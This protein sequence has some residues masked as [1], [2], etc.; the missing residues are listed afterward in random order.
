MRTMPLRSARRAVFLTL[1]AAMVL[2]LSLNGVGATQ[3]P[4]VAVAS[5]PAAPD[6]MKQTRAEMEAKS[7]GCVT[8]H[9][10]TEPMHEAKTVKLVFTDCHGGDAAATVKELAHVKPRHPELWKTAANPKGSFSALNRE[11]PEFVKFVNPSDLR[12][13]P[14]TC[15]TATCHAKEVANVS[16]SMMTHGAMLW[17]AALYNNGSYPSKTYRFGESYDRDGNPRRLVTNPPPTAAE[18]AKGVLPFLDPL[19]RW[20]VTQPGNVLRVFERGGRPASQTGLP[21]KEEAPGRPEVKL[22]VRGVG[23]NLRTDPVFLNLQKTRVLD[24]SLSF[25]GT[26]D[27]AGDYRSSGCAACHVPYANDRDPEH[28]GPWAVH[29][30]QGQSAQADPT[31]PKYEPGHPIK[32]QFTRAIPSSQCMVCHMHQGNA[33]VNSYYGAIW[34]DQETDGALMYPK[35][36]LDP[37]SKRVAEVHRHNP[38]GAAERG[39]WGDEKFLSKVS[40][41]NPKMRHTQFADYHGHGW[42]F[43]YVYKQ[44]RKGNLLDAKGQQVSHADPE[45]FK[46]AVHLKDIH[47][48]K[49]MHCVDCHF[50]KDSHGNGKLYGEIGNAIEIDCIDCHGTIDR[51]ANLVTSGTMAG[52]GTSLAPLRTPFGKKRFEFRSGKLLQ[53]SMV[54]QGVEWEVVQTADTVDPT[55]PH[56]SERSRLAKTLRKDG[57]SWGDVP[58]SEAQLA[59]ANN[60]M[61]CYACHSAWITSCFGCHLPMKANVRKPM[62]HNEGDVTRNYTTY[63]PQVLRDDVYMLGV[64]GTAKGNRVA[65]VRSSSAIIV[66]STNANREALYSQQQTFSAGGYS[67]QAFNPHVPHT[68]RSTETK[69]CT[70][71][72]VSRKGDNNAWMAQLLLQGTNF[73]NFMGRYAYVAEGHEGLEAVVVTERDEPQAVIGSYLQSIAYPRNFSRFVKEGRKLD[74]AYEHDGEEIRSLQLRGEYLYTARGPGGFEIYDVANIDN[75]GFSERIISS[76]VSPLGQRTFVR[77]KYATAVALPSTL[78]VDTRR[79]DRPENQEQKAHPIYDYAFVTDRHEGLIVIDTH[80]LYDGDP[81]NNFMRRAATW[82]PDGVLDGAENIT[83][84]GNFA[85]VS[86]RKGLVIVD[87]DRPTEPKLAAVVGAPSI[88]EPRFVAVQFRYAFVCDRHGVQVLDV[89]DPRSPRAVPGA[90]IPLRDARSIYLARTYAY[91]AAGPKGLVILDVENP[92]KPFID[93]TFDDGGR[94]N[95]AHDVKVASTNASLFA[96]IADGENGLKVLQL[97]SPEETPGNYGFSPRPAPRVI[98]TYKTH[99]PALAL[100]KGLDRDRAVD[101]SYNQVAVFGRLGSRPF[102]AD[103]AR[104]LF[105]DAQGKPYSVSDEPPGPAT[106]HASEL[107]PAEP[108]AP[109]AGAAPSEPPATGRRLR[110]R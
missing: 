12:V 55:S 74:E 5:Q 13:A 36:Q 38:E 28:S 59:H 82:N 106:P 40:E 72:H 17:G 96:Y 64:N 15:G 69:L 16:K 98:A 19:P 81:E 4:A 100:S 37:D 24:P 8:C 67:G 2:G 57:K 6:L 56:Y 109:P 51:K 89:T 9:K 49:G 110:R 97:T 105:V 85:Y 73:T 79:G 45:K 10:D 84:A 52:E 94:L 54:K 42:V 88:R 48:E 29:G 101:E 46:K 18:L 53:R 70:D 83:I 50:E 107:K 61:T 23:T 26:N 77:S 87:L 62:L 3:A 34:W 75:K 78:Y 92:E 33:F 66:G 91:V 20:E 30:H 47:L 39:L 27:H 102:K 14:M 7:R 22:S 68:V 71:C 60:K 104:K 44:D 43:R 90:T 95:D 65:P 86:T 58:A 31:I 103:E 32:H 63:N 11:S 80:C 25:M 99:G 41:L 93:Q 1:A 108:P 21:D 35:Q 76:P